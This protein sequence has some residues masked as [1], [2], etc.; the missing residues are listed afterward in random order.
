MVSINAARSSGVNMHGTSP[1]FRRLFTSSTNASVFICASERRKTTCSPAPPE[2]RS[3]FFKS[4]LHSATPYVF[5]IST[6][7]SRI[8]HTCADR[9]VS[10]CLPE[11]PTPTRSNDPPGCPNT[12]V[13]LDTCSA[14][15]RNIARFIGDVDAALCESRYR[16]RVFTSA[17]TSVISAYARRRRE[18]ATTIASSS[19]TQPSSS[20][21]P[22]SSSSSSVAG[23]RM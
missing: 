10:D 5:E 12:R 20:P 11:P 22:S 1:A 3:I 19:S 16:S 4:S 8:P 7:S 23:P 21:L 2:A 6:R 13:I 14:V 9:R 18:D 15:Y 17:S